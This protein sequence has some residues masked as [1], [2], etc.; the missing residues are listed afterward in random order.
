[1]FPAKLRTSQPTPPSRM[2]QTPAAA[3]GQ[4][5]LPLPNALSE[6]MPPA[7]VTFDFA[8]LTPGLRLILIIGAFGG[9]GG[10]SGRGA[11]RETHRK[12]QQRSDF[13]H[14]DPV[15]DPDRKSTRLNSSHASEPRL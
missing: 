13:V 2:I 1:M 4:G 7:R 11:Q 14:V 5:S 3:N 10:N 8:R 9:E 12:H 6:L 15:E